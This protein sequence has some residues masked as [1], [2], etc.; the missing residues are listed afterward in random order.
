[1]AR[2]AGFPVP[3]PIGLGQDSE[4]SEAELFTDRL[5]AWTSLIEAATEAGVGEW[6]DSVRLSV[7]R[8]LEVEVAT[9]GGTGFSGTDEDTDRPRLCQEPGPD[10]RV[11]ALAEGH[12]GAHGSGSIQ[13]GDPDHSVEIP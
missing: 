12:G 7:A 5:H 2:L 9:A 6:A 8:M 11:C 1:M 10:G 4:R 3:I 13:W